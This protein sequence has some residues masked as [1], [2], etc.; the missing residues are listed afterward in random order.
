M[1]L[2]C[3][4]R[5]MRARR[6]QASSSLRAYPRT[7]QSQYSSSKQVSRTSTKTLSVRLLTPT[8]SISRSPFV[9]HVWDVWEEL[10][11]SRFRVGLHDRAR[12]AFV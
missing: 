12:F 9:S 6:L 5:F 3:E 1:P 10:F 4:I 7:P 2:K 11:Q 8:L